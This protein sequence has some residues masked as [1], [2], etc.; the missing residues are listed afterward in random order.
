MQQMVRV[1]NDI[2][3]N[4][5]DTL[6]LFRITENTLKKRIPIKKQILLIIFSCLYSIPENMPF[7]SF[8]WNGTIFIFLSIYV[9]NKFKT[10]IKIYLTYKIILYVISPIL[11]F[12]HTF[13]LL[14][15]DMAV[16]SYYESYKG[17]IIMFLIYI[18]Y[19]LY[20]NFKR[21]KNF[22][23]H[24]QTYFNIIILGISLLHSFSTLYICREN[25]ESYILPI[26]FATIA[27]LIILCISL[28][29]RFLSLIEENT[30]HKI[31]FEIQRMQTAY[32]A[33]IEANL[34]DLHSIRHDIKN[35]LII[36]DGYASQHNHEKIREY[37]AKIADTF[38]S[39]PLLETPS[40]SISALLNEKYHVAKRAGIDCR[41]LTEFSKVS[42][43]DFSMIT[44]LGNLLDN[45][46][47]AA[48]KC[49][50]GWIHAELYQSGSYL[51]ITIENNHR[52][53]IREKNGAYRTTKE[54]KPQIHG[55]GIKNVRKV[56][57]TLN[58]QITIS[59]TLNTFCVNILVPNY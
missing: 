47:T 7:S 10:G 56:V 21:M 17:T 4:L 12:A 40:A 44:I 38:H 32:A 19:V 3:F 45:A 50:N 54:E 33:Q 11:V 57:D 2:L 52:E 31:Q 15:K 49:D 35:H 39:E 26:I 20:I 37:I 48:A 28:Y 23:T 42:V 1:Y 41:I 25:S 8:I 58:G 53:S 43:D 51:E 27:L 22:Y 29:D 30:K 6:F 14:D 24:Y 16:V 55:I 36:I 5:F 46:I 9:Q 13:I 34:K 59:H 18:F